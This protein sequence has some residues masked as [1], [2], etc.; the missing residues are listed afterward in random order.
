MPAIELRTGTARPPRPEDYCTKIAA[1]APSGDCP[2]W[3]NFLK[4]VTADDIE[5]QAYLQRVA[6]YCMTGL[7]IEQVIFFLYGTGANGK[8][9]FINT[10]V[11]IWRDY[12]VTASMETFVES[13]SDRHPTE[14]AHLEGARLVVANETESGR[15]WAES[16]IKQLTGGERIAARFM[17]GDFFQFVPQFKIVIV[18][19]HKPTLNT[20]N[21]AIRRRFHLVPFTVTIPPEERDPHLAEKLETEWPGILQWAIEGCLEWQRI[22]LDPP[23]AVLAATD[24]YLAEEDTFARW[25]GECCVTGQQHWGIGTALWSS[26]KRWAEQNN[27]PPGSQKS[28]SQ[29]MVARG[30]ATDRSQ[31]VRGFKGISL[32]S[33]PDDERADFR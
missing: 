20:V 22:G 8:S 4:R 2:L 13:N 28:F 16:R 18:G 33:N 26:W 31:R 21:E 25:I 30:F 6:G 1:V 3:K 5:L 10:L 24:E 9:V 17:R 11:A 14:L 27:E 23:A 32:R 12:A 29:T 15:R 7:T 19:N